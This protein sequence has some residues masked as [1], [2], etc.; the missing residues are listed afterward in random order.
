MTRKLLSIITPC[1]NEELNVVECRETTRRIVETELPEY[2]HEHIF[3]DNAST[4]RTLDLLRE[5]AAADPRVR[6]IASRGDAVLLCLAADL[7]DPPEL[8]PQFVRL[9]EQGHEVVYG[10]RRWREESFIL[11]NVRKLYYRLVHETSNIA[12]HQGAGEFQ[13][14]DR[15][16]VAALRQFDD[17][18]PYVRGMVAYCGF[19]SVGVD[20]TW[21]SRKRGIS[22]NN[23]VRLVDQALNGL[24]SFTN[25]PMRLCMGAGLAIATASFVFGLFSLVVNLVYFRQLAPP[26]IPT[27]IVAVFFFSGIQLFA[28]GVLGEYISAIHAQVRKRPVVVE[29]ERINFEPPEATTP[30]AAGEQRPA[31]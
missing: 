11:R 20:Y 10:V 4:D 24:I 12:M 13:V 9:W 2:D 27:L 15:K 21:K 6:V 19:R 7:Q 28:F 18:Y 5:L 8:I 31:I 3:C 16:V 25:V 17:Y 30:A 23:F 29:R 1:Y 14:V 22:K 26:G